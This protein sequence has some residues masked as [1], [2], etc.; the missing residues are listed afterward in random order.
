VYIYLTPFFN[1]F[2]TMKLYW[3]KFGLQS[4]TQL[5]KTKKKEKLFASWTSLSSHCWI[6]FISENLSWFVEQNR[7]K[8]VIDRKK[9]ETRWEKKRRRILPRRNQ[10]PSVE[11]PAHKSWIMFQFVNVKV[12]TNFNPFFSLYPKSCAPILWLIFSILEKMAW[13]KGH[14]KV[15]R[16]SEFF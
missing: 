8:R 5:W 2:F 16:Y 13:A 11:P 12:A 4:A 3:L 10:P 6:F 14:L 7:T 9:M 1:F 15:E